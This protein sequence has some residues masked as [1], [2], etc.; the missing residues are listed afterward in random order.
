MVLLCVIANCATLDSVAL[1][2]NYWISLLHIQNVL[3]CTNNQEVDIAP[4]FIIRDFRC[5]MTSL[6]DRTVQR[7][8]S[9]DEHSSSC[10]G[11]LGLWLIIY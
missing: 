6:S 7:P 9:D 11:R 8:L 10:T 3:L 4:L 2:V 5:I 1:C